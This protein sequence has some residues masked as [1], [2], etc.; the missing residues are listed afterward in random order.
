MGLVGEKEKC[1]EKKK[2]GCRLFR[3]R[4]L[5]SWSRFRAF[6]SS[7]PGNVALPGGLNLQA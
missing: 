6:R 1:G 3:P 4:A 7:L 2:K 5:P